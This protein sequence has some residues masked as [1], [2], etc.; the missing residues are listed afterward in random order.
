[1]SF[2]CMEL[3]RP[4][5]FDFHGVSMTHYFTDSWDK[6]QNFKARP[7]DIVIAT[8][9]KAGTTWVSQI[10]D[11]L[12]FGKSDPGRQTS[13][14]IY[15]RVPF[16]EI[17][18]RNV[19]TGAEL[20]EKMTSVPRIIKT[21]F[22]VQFV[23][24][25]FWE[26]NCK[27]IYVARNAKDNVVSYFHFDRMNIVQPEPGDWPSYLQRF[28]EGK[29]VFGSWYNHVKGWWEKKQTYGNIHYM[30]YEDLA[31]DTA[32]E[33]EKICSFLNISPTQEEKDH[34]IKEV[35]FDTMKKNKMANYSTI[36]VMDFK[37][38]P[39]MRKGK[40]SDW[41]NHFTVAQNEQ[42]DEVYQKKMANTTLRFRTEI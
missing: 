20:A 40:V 39:F 34:V 12:Y 3:N 21:H 33:I 32:Q 1:M 31:E 22:P 2:P 7:D 27:L 18:I 41:K 4:E 19:P 8:Y 24:K 13:I 10:L 23:P 30:F 5:L 28:Q 35:A 17:R 9:A 42:F 11:L 25:S 15:E 26:Q 6:V 36:G 29:V 16:L 14:P 37:I 38:S